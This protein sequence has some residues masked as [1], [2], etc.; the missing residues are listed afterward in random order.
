MTLQGLPRCLSGKESACPRRRCGFHPWVR[1]I[2]GRRKGQPTP[3]LLP[4]ESRGQKS[5]AGYSPWGH[6]ELDTTERL[7]SSSD[8]YRVRLKSLMSECKAGDSYPFLCNPSLRRLAGSCGPTPE[9]QCGARALSADSVAVFLVG[10]LAPPPGWVP[11]LVFRAS[12]SS[13]PEKLLFSGW[14]P[15]AQDAAARVPGCAWGPAVGLGNHLSTYQREL[16]HAASYSEA[17]IG[18]LPITFSQ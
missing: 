2:H 3:V 17:L 11:A 18:I 15:G 8:A 7:T 12:R 6:T 16:S 13:L 10:R 14:S 9:R 1:T 4:G 5:L